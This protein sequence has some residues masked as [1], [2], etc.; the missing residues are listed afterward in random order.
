MSLKRRQWFCSLMAL[1]HLPPKFQCVC[2][3]PGPKY[4]CARK[5]NVFCVSLHW[6]FDSI[7][8]GFCQDESRYNVERSATAKSSKPQTSTPTGTSRKRDGELHHKGHFVSS[9]LLPFL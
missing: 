9:A 2:P 6:L 7:E 5:W 1:S 3:C 8:K 4:E